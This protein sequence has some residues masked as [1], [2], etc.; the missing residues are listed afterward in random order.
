MLDFSLRSSDFLN[1]GCTL[2]GDAS[3]V[4]GNPSFPTSATQYVVFESVSIGSNLL[5]WKKVGFSQFTV[6]IIFPSI[7]ISNNNFRNNSLWKCLKLKS[8]MRFKNKDSALFTKQALTFCLSPPGPEAKI[9][10]VAPFRLP[11]S[12]PFR[13]KENVGNR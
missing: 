5:S 3:A 4:P 10:E 12:F 9:N 6:F 7:S 13:V 11:I 1:I 2:S 8:P